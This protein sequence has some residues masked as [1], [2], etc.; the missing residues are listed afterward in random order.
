MKTVEGF[1]LRK[2]AG[3]MIISGESTAQVNFNKLRALHDSAAYLWQ[4]IENTDFSVDT[5][6]GLLVEKYSIEPSLAKEDAQ[7]IADS[8]IEVGIVR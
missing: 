7:K 8:W 4:Q 3:E 5:L 6:A 1:K 2:V